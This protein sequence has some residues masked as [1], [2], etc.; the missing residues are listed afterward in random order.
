MITR[1]AV[2]RV[3]FVIWPVRVIAGAGVCVIVVS[4]VC[5]I[6]GAGVCVIVVSASSV[7]TT[8]AASRPQAKY[9][10]IATSESRA[11]EPAPI[12]CAFHQSPV[13]IIAIARPAVAITTSVRHTPAVAMP[14]VFSAAAIVRLSSAVPEVFFATA[15]LGEILFPT[16][17]ILDV[18]LAAAIAVAPINGTS[19]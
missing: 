5:V 1:G 13:T 17:A 18:F 8:S 4:A 12:V 7:S 6:A 14:D 9:G 10:S 2:R 16:T 3:C 15:S 19:A 11:T